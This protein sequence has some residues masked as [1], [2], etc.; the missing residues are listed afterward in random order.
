[1]KIEL[2]LVDSIDEDGSEFELSVY[3]FN[4]FNIYVNE[5]KT[6]EK[7]LKNRESFDRCMNIRNKFN[8]EFY[9][10]F[11][12]EIDEEFNLKLK[13]RD[14]Y[15]CQN[16]ENILDSVEFIKL[17]FSTLN[18]RKFINDN[19][20]VLSKKIV[21]DE[22]LRITDYDKLLELM[23]EYEDIIDNVYINLV[24]NR[25]YVSL[26]DCYKTINAVKKQAEDI[27][28]LNLSPMETI[29]YV[30]DLVRNR[31]YTHELEDE[32]ATKSRD[33][34][35]VMFGDKIVC[36]G[37][38]NYFSALLYYLGI[39][40]DI[41]LLYEKENGINVSGHARNLVYVKDSKYDI[42]GVYYFDPTWDSKKKENNNTYLYRYNYF[43][44]TRS[45]MDNDKN[46]KFDDQKFPLYSKDMYN[47]IRKIINEGNYEKLL[48]YVQSV[49][50]MSFIV[51]EDRLLDRMHLH[52]IS[53]RY[54]K[55]DSKKFLRKFKKVFVK[56]DKELPAEVMIPLLNNVRKIEYYQNPDWYLYSSDDIYKTFMVSKWKFKDEHY[57]EKIKLMIAIFGDEVKD[58]INPAEIFGNYGFSE[59]LFEDVEHVR[60]AKVLHKVLDKK[61]N[62]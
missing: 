9:E 14:D 1:M 44:K 59:G 15:I 29:M 34:K 47:E 18:P 2:V 27:K 51:G 50:Y 32:S 40:S 48:P 17:S 39:Y 13:Q 21:L 20:I 60:L 8:D 55:F 12:E 62:I 28:K 25:D 53:P 52:P 33:L 19:P 46:H 49:N 4:N 10:E 16:F 3:P 35:E 43:A 57:S 11:D 31:V 37:Y 22:E 6:L 54:G 61:N 7:Q 30:Y 42:D 26:I 41:V 38:A 58:K 56:F 23:K 45:F 24:G 5:E 36:L